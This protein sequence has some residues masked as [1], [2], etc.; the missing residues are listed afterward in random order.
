M[1]NTNKVHEKKRN[2]PIDLPWSRPYPK[3]IPRLNEI[4]FYDERYL[5]K[6]FIN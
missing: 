2:F 1:G 6:R 4:H 3:P 5:K